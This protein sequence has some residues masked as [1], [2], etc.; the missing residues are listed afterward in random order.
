MTNEEFIKLSNEIA[1][2]SK[3]PGDKPVV[4]VTDYDATLDDMGLDSLDFITYFIYF[5]DIFS[6]EDEAFNN[7]PNIGD[8]KIPSVN[9]LIRVANDIG[10]PIAD[11][12]LEAALATL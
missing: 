7:H 1:K 8:S 11:V 12:D 3:T 6:I 10:T 2:A 4:E 9:N 5:C